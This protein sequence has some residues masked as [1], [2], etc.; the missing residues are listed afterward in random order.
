MNAR[1]VITV[2]LLASLVPVQAAAQAPTGTPQPNLAIALE[3][4]GQEPVWIHGQPRNAE[5]RAT[6]T[7][8]GST[9][10]ANYRVEYVWAVD[11]AEAWLNGAQTTSFDVG[12]SLSNTPGQNS[13]I[14]PA[15]WTLGPQQQGAGTLIARV[16]PT[17][18]DGKAEDNVAA[19]PMF[20]Q[21]H[22][23]RTSVAT[24]DQS[25]RPDETRFF[26][27]GITNHGNV[28]EP[29][30]F[31]SLAPN[32]TGRLESTLQ[33]PTISSLSS[34]ATAN[35]T[36]FVTYPFSGDSSGFN[37]SYTYSVATQYGRTI[38][39]QSRAFTSS[40][41]LLQ[42]PS[43]FSLLVNLDEPIVVAYRGSRTVPVTLTN[44]GSIPD[45]YDVNAEPSDG[46]AAE[47]SHR[48]GLLSGESR[49][50][51][52]TIFAE[53][54]TPRGH[55][56]DVR[57]SVRSLRTQQ[58]T[59]VTA[60]A[61]VDGAALTLLPGTGWDSVRY[62][63][64]PQNYVV[65]VS[66]LGDAPTA[67][68]GLLRLET[69]V[70]GAA[71]LTASVAPLAPGETREV[72]LSGPPHASSGTI[73]LRVLWQAPGDAISFLP[74]ED[75]VFV[76]QGIL[77]V[78]APAQ[79]LAGQPGELVR[80]QGAAYSFQLKNLGNAVETIE[81]KANASGGA[82]KTSLGQIVL[83]PNDPPRQI[84]VDHLLPKPAGSLNAAK[85]TLYASIAGRPLTSWN[86]TVTTSIVDRDWPLPKIASTLP[87]EWA[88]N[89]PLTV[90]AS[91]L[92]DGQVATARTILRGPSG[93]KTTLNMSATS[94]GLWTATL[95]PS[96]R[97]THAVWINA[98]DGAGHSTE[99]AAGE[100]TTL[101]VPPPRV[102]LQGP[103]GGSTVAPDQTFTVI[104]DDERPI[105]R[106]TLSIKGPVG[107][108]TREVPILA[109]GLARF[110]LA[111]APSGNV[112]IHVE[113]VN[114]AGARANVTRVLVVDRPE[115]SPQ[116]SP[117]NTTAASLAEAPGATTAGPSIILASVAFLVAGF[118]GTRNS[119]KAG[120][121]GSKLAPSTSLMSRPRGLQ[122]APVRK[123]AGGTTSPETRR[124][125]QR[126]PRLMSAAPEPRRSP[127]GPSGPR[128][129]RPLG[130]SA[131]PTRS[132]GTP[133]GKLFAVSVVA[134]LLAGVF[135]ALAMGRDQAPASE[136]AAD[137]VQDSIEAHGLSQFLAS[138][139]EP[140]TPESVLGS[141]AA[142]WFV[143]DDWTRPAA[144][145]TGIAGVVD[146]ISPGMKRPAIPEPPTGPE[147]LL[148]AIVLYAE[149]VGVDVPPLDVLRSAIDLLLLQP[150]SEAALAQLVVAYQQ[151]L[152]LRERA[153]LP[154]D[155]A[156]PPADWA[157]TSAQ[158]EQSLVAADLVA[159][160][161]EHVKDDLALPPR[162]LRDDTTTMGPPASR[163]S[164]AEEARPSAIPN[165]P[166]STSP[167]AGV[168][169]SQASL[170]ARLDSVDLSRFYETQSGPWQ[171]LKEIILLAAP[172]TPAELPTVPRESL[173]QAVRNFGI[174]MGL[175]PDVPL[176]PVALPPSLESAIAGIV[177][178]R[179]VGLESGD[180]AI[181][182]ALIVDATERARPTVDAWQ[183]LWQLSND[184]GSHVRS[185]L[186]FVE[187]LDKDPAAGPTALLRSRTAS[188]DPAQPDLANAMLEPIPLGFGT[189]PTAV[190][191]AAATLLDAV[192]ALESARVQASASLSDS[193][194]AA[195]AQTEQVVVLLERARWS[196]AQAALVETWAGA[197]QKMSAPD[198]SGPLEDAQADVLQA[199]EDA[200][201]ILRDALPQP[202]SQGQSSSDEPNPLPIPEPRFALGGVSAPCTELPQQIPGQLTS[203]CARDV[204]L[205]S[206]TFLVT[207]G[208]STTIDASFGNPLIIIDLGGDDTYI[209]P[210]AVAAQQPVSIVI[211]L[212]GNDLY[213][214][215]GTSAHGVGIGPGT[216]GVLFDDEGDDTY[217]HAPD[218]TATE[219]RAQGLGVSGG[220]GVL[221]DRGGSDRYI[222]ESSVGH[223]ASAGLAAGGGI[224]ILFDNGTGSDVFQVRRGQGFADTANGLG[225]LTNT[226]GTNEY[227]TVIGSP[228]FQGGQDGNRPGAVGLLIDLGGEGTFYSNDALPTGAQG[229]STQG[230]PSERQDEALW[231]SFQGTALGMGLDSTLADEDND[232]LPNL[233]EMLGGSDLL[234]LVTGLLEGGDIPPELPETGDPTAFLNSLGGAGDESLDG[235]GRDCGDGIGSIL[236]IGTPGPDDY[237]N[238]ALILIDPGGSDTYHHEVAGPG[239]FCESGFA[240][241]GVGSIAIDF[242]GDDHYATPDRTFTQA[243]IHQ[244]NIIFLPPPFPTF[245]PPNPQVLTTWATTVV[246]P[247]LP[248]QGRLIAPNSVLLEVQGNDV[249]EAGSNS[250]AA[251]QEDFP[252]GATTVSFGN[253]WLIDLAGNDE[254]SGTRQ[255]SV[256]HSGGAGLIDLTGD[257]KYWFAYQATVV[258]GVI[259]SAPFAILV[260][261]G[262]V[263]Y[264]ESTAVPIDVAS[265][266]E[267][268]HRA[269][270][271]QGNGSAK[272]VPGGDK[273]TG[274][275]IENGQDID[276]YKTLNT[277]GGL[278]DVSAFK[279]NAISGPIHPSTGT[280]TVQVPGVGGVF[281]DNPA[282]PA[283]PYLFATSPQ[284]ADNDGAPNLI[285][286]V[287][288][289]S[290]T[291]S[292]DAPGALWTSLPG[293]PGAIQAAP[294]PAGAIGAT[295]VGTAGFW[296][297]FHNLAMG[298][299][300]NSIIQTSVPFMVELGG[301]DDYVSP[302]LGQNGHVLL[303]VGP[304]NDR[305][306]PPCTLSI[307]NATGSYELCQNLGGSVFDTGGNNLFRTDALFDDVQVG[308][309]LN[310]K[311][312]QVNLATQGA[313]FNA[314]T[315][316]VPAA[317]AML[318]SWNAMNTFQTSVTVRRDG[319]V[320][321]GTT[322]NVVVVTQGSQSHVGLGQDDESAILASFGSG[323]DSYSF[324]V[325]VELLNGNY[326]AP[327]VTTIAQGAG[328]NRAIL[329]DDGGSNQ[330]IAPN[331]TSQGSGGG[332]LWS[333]A[334][335]D[336]YVAGGCSQGGGGRLHDSGGNDAYLITAAGCGV[337]GQ[338]S[339]GTLV[340]VSGDDNYVSL[341]PLSQGAIGTL[342]DLGG[343]DQYS[344]TDKAQG[345]SEGGSRGYFIDAS[346]R[347]RYSIDAG[348]RGQ[349]FMLGCGFTQDSAAVFF[350]GGGRDEYTYSFEKTSLDGQTAPENRNDW[351]WTQPV[352][353]CPTPLTIQVL[354]QPPTTV[355]PPV[356][357]TPNLA[358]TCPLVRGIDTSSLRAQGTPADPTVT[359]QLTPI[360]MDG[361]GNPF[362]AET[363]VARALVQN[364]PGNNPQSIRRVTF[365]LEDRT[366][367][368]G[369]F[370]GVVNN[371]ALAYDFAWN[372]ASG[373]FPDGSN[374]IWATVF[375]GESEGS[376]AVNQNI[377]G[378]PV[379]QNG[380]GASPDLPGFDSAPIPINVDNAPTLTAIVDRNVI[381]PALDQ[382]FEV[383]FT[384]G[385]DAK[386][387]DDPDPRCPGDTPG[388]QVTIVARGPQDQ[389]VFDGY[390]ASGTFSLS[391]KPQVGT[392]VNAVDWANGLY[393]LDVLAVDARENE[394][395]VRIPPRQDGL[396]A[397]LLVDGQAPSSTILTPSTAGLQWRVG[398]ALK[399][400]WSA[401]DGAGSGVER[402]CLSRLSAT[403]LPV[404]E[405]AFIDCFPS[406]LSG[407]TIAGVSTGDKVFI[408][409]GAHDN[410]GNME[411]RPVTLA[412]AKE[413]LIDFDEP[414][415]EG[416]LINSLLP[417]LAYIKPGAPVNFTVRTTDEGAGIHNVVLSLPA[418]LTVTMDTDGLGNYWYDEWNLTNP[419][420]HASGN[421][422]SPFQFRVKVS[423]KA[424]NSLGPGRGDFSSTLDSLE[425]RASI[426]STSYFA[427]GQEDR[428]LLIGRPGLTAK[429]EVNV[430]DEA[431]ASVEFDPRSFSSATAFVPCARPPISTNPNLWVCEREVRP[432]LAS[433]DY[434]VSI[435]AVDEAGNHKVLAATVKIRIEPPEFHDITVKEKGPT[436]FLVEWTTPFPSS[437]KVRYG[438]QLDSDAPTVTVPGFR[439][440]HSVM[441][442][443]LAPSTVYSFIVEATNEAGVPSQSEP[444][445]ETTEAG[446]EFGFDT[447]PCD[448]TQF[449]TGEAVRGIVQI[450]YGYKP[451]II[452][453]PAHITFRIQELGRSVSPVDLAAV[454]IDT[455]CHE[456]ELNATALSDGRYSITVDIDRAG[457]QSRYDSP[458][459]MVDN[460]PPAA[461]LV[462]PAAA[463]KLTDASPEI[464]LALLDP[465]GEEPPEVASLAIEVNDAPVDHEIISV[466]LTALESAQSR[467]TLRLTNPLD[468]GTNWINITVRDAA[469]N[470][471]RATTM[472]TVDA[473]EPQLQPG[474]MVVPRPGPTAARPGGQV[475]VSLTLRDASRVA[476]AY[477]DLSAL[478]G[479]RTPLF[480]RDGTV[481]QGTFTLPTNVTEG[482]LILPVRARDGLGNEGPAGFLEVSVDADAPT[483]EEPQI[484]AQGY[485]WVLL[486]VQTNEPTQAWHS[487]RGKQ[488]PEA[489][490][491]T[492]HD[493]NLTGL[494][495]GFDQLGR[496]V[497]VDQAGNR[498][499]AFTRIKTMADTAPPSAVSNFT[500]SSEKDGVVLLAWSP[501]F[502][503]V[504]LAHYNLERIV[505]GR[506]T[507]STL[508]G[509][510]R[511]HVDDKAPAGQKVR[512][513]LLAVDMADN[514]GPTSEVD[515]AVLAAPRLSAAIVSPVRGRA[516]EPFTVRV[517]YAHATG[518]APDNISVHIG[519]RVIPMTQVGAG[520]CSSGCQFSATLLLE[521]TDQFTAAHAITIHATTDGHETVQALEYQP[522]V[523]AGNGIVAKAERSRGGSAPLDPMISFIALAFATAVFLR[524]RLNP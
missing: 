364:V 474:A 157:P 378:V 167:G 225:V 427:R 252:F 98:T 428:Q 10:S 491:S 197:M 218:N 20:I 148:A 257:D 523:Q 96:E 15:S 284:D 372:T 395:L 285:E 478:D 337:G 3:I 384:L 369:V 82:A 298:G 271:T 322:T 60:P 464:E 46:W 208:A 79:A 99:V 256:T 410:A 469:G 340:D 516:D 12:N 158:L 413:V 433:G 217:R 127:A 266:S 499:E 105:S 432:G 327:T 457:D 479:K 351:N 161:V 450:S 456:L 415:L 184:A 121:V 514:H 293:A 495:P 51:M 504:G 465:L 392:G 160:T 381:S 258:A 255:A 308:Q 45:V 75:D 411:A 492:T 458:E 417:H 17:G 330:F 196:S 231:I 251:A 49:T 280:G 143:D 493:I 234:T 93:A 159:R 305:Y 353:N 420:L 423:D 166:A 6:V 310:D 435:H 484:V 403:G 9:S 380:H 470:I 83:S 58:P 230:T 48:V 399:V 362:I 42:A 283:A 320:A 343:H 505:G 31:S 467:V 462:R 445:S 519:E 109:S 209:V 396:A 30:S 181:A 71:P 233:A 81:L 120:K 449:P 275:F 501:P 448:E 190:G 488:D 89:Q 220:V 291:D 133:K 299:Q 124:S 69:N 155:A 151:S 240:I 170:A 56:A 267:S 64:D 272:S 176:P 103:K 163:T 38:S 19:I 249:Y 319:P 236:F 85:V 348:G 129:P 312:V 205:Q 394:R 496:I 238:P 211:D 297:H 195:L 507:N 144:Q 390:C 430:L 113:A 487:T 90:R 302:G 323:A 352:A 370:N 418:G 126:A 128:V 482:T 326:Q 130:Q 8:T 270:D 223:G 347:D 227:E 446:Y 185:P 300:G 336:T 229:L 65:A 385:D 335:D 497:L 282:T 264:Y 426:L 134:T 454:D 41:T 345:Y 28:L 237:R 22:D 232:N 97:G 222:A 515:I 253:A 117:T 447:E 61:R 350:D 62:L 188:N 107:T 334:G 391:F 138:L 156:H 84:S 26:R 59:T 111:D 498:G 114:N 168:E 480:T 110:D 191:E 68:G 520:D 118:L 366:L 517:T 171:Y 409:S 263:D 452:G 444:R 509:N 412:S 429:V 338:G 273:P 481:W 193:E 13:R 306:L 321:A 132:P 125:G 192:E 54:D 40:Y 511:S 116:N 440:S 510:A 355:Q 70:V 182:S 139:P 201:A 226:D 73:Q 281:L 77:E 503:N 387:I 37:A 288:G 137:L 365:L 471:G 459:F 311:D 269:F 455:G 202:G 142:S 494:R 521:S 101:P 248:G 379:N 199:V 301:N 451:R 346:G 477:I 383:T 416:V 434:P 18:S 178:A 24:A 508:D 136:T 466:E 292:D 183:A 354:T 250:Q 328:S 39:N 349:G 5:L 174:L 318:V 72:M 140:L 154:A 108:Q 27:I 213:E 187:L 44:E 194:R 367:G 274:F 200:A 309:G 36:V 475:E 359:V 439:T 377:G 393:H 260:E 398:Q 438:R 373:A 4:V 74:L 207:G 146:L 95:M 286:T 52:V 421:R 489:P 315:G 2:V 235:W 47:M 78:S 502:D 16:I 153:G 206:P 175:G 92:D 25:I 244:D 472:L 304:G 123:K 436:S 522:F 254:Y 104:A 57:F 91:I 276:T 106:I 414:R 329:F 259:S 241:W 55:A 461:L 287:V 361:A 11:G 88:I 243:A 524:R 67:S 169:P 375:L 80:Y 313:L 245:V 50:W 358:G 441:V 94:S 147:P 424:L 34:G 314:G 422:E 431:L 289:R 112:T 371:N 212:A 162:E 43:P 513:I 437:T 215:G 486:R 324:D 389:V 177:S 141:S 500:A 357:C 468:E 29:I 386:F 290:P 23:V 463:S 172:K 66:N 224:G 277:Q 7:N 332:I 87:S 294:N 150:E 483:A 164:W 246:I 32:I 303:D 404:D 485:S 408:V 331:G 131:K 460:T 265:L 189:L 180:A 518:R 173:E 490:W 216:I 63:G 374:K 405:P 363:V 262:G 476:A 341:Q 76:R 100:F 219:G 221:V 344:A 179:R 356:Q 419:A 186:P 247:Y 122:Y 406:H 473:T 382:E 325:T 242:G 228:A 119:Q 506:S 442:P 210:V 317:P 203:N 333:G 214:S 316:V 86:A 342:L 35:Q 152:V 453:P 279:N 198:A 145:P 512:Y 14:H 401:A 397:T 443:N 135:G 1:V 388:G 402:V 295:G 53:S 368:K 425:P 21:V 165:A 149:F 407:A 339:S 33:T 268:P 239:H 307:R 400:G 278:S 261:G 204:W 115:A 360:Q 296:L 102:E 376:T